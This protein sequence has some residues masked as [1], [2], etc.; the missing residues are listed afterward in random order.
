MAATA[1]LRTRRAT[2]PLP[3]GDL[4]RRLLQLAAGAETILFDRAARMVR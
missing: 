4:L 1:G 3:G 2:E